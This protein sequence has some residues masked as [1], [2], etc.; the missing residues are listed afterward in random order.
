MASRPCW[1]IKARL[2]EED[3]SALGELRLAVAED[4]AGGAAGRRASPLVGGTDEAAGAVRG[5]RVEAESARACRAPELRVVRPAR[6]GTRRER[7]DVALGSTVDDAE[8]SDAERERVRGVLDEWS[9]LDTISRASTPGLPHRL[10][11]RVVA[12][13]FDAGRVYRNFR[14]AARCAIPPP[15]PPP[16]RLPPPPPDDARSCAAAAAGCQDAASMPSPGQ[17]LAS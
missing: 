8:P 4:D 11:P 1:P 17:S 16:C 2:N 5:A 7:S 15:L 9:D 6:A 3:G 13:W 12:Q 14:A 10:V